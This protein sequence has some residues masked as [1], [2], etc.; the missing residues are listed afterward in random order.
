MRGMFIRDWKRLWLW[1]VCGLLGTACLYPW[2]CATQGTAIWFAILIQ[3]Y[4]MV[5]LRSLV[6]ED[7][8]T[9][10]DRYTGVFPNGRRRYAAGKITVLLTVWTALLLG[11]FLGR[12][13]QALIFHYGLS[14][15]PVF[16]NLHYPTD[17]F[18]YLWYMLAPDSVYDLIYIPIVGSFGEVYLFTMTALQL[19][20]LLFLPDAVSIL[21]DAVTWFGAFMGIFWIQSGFSRAFLAAKNA[22][23]LPKEIEELQALYYLYWNDVPWDILMWP[24][25]ALFL[26][27]AG[28]CI[29]YAGKRRTDGK[30]PKKERKHTLYSLRTPLLLVIGAGLLVGTAVQVWQELH[31][32]YKTYVYSYED[33]FDERTAYEVTDEEPEEKLKYNK[34]GDTPYSLAGVYATEN[35]EAQTYNA[36]G[37]KLLV[38]DRE[39]LLYD[40]E[41]EEKTVLALD[42]QPERIGIMLLGTTEPLAIAVDRKANEC[43]YFS[44][45]ENRMMTEYI[46][47]SVRD[48]YLYDGIIRT[49][50]VHK[51]KYKEDSAVYYEINPVTWE[52]REVKAE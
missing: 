19:P 41:M 20:V 39:W 14:D 11:I 26:L 23:N 49:F 13:I 36:I 22:G 42:A 30:P 45:R 38:W 44:I 37:G 16:D 18:G 9:G 35:P 47:P 21:W 32:V 31:P 12:L 51:I 27:S 24:A 7:R 52:I 29:W 3:I 40:L 6:R 46:Y 15:S 5:T 48:E 33:R 34:Y 10:W 17:L 50:K 1:L 43:A 8:M 4:G 25:L 28:F 2:S